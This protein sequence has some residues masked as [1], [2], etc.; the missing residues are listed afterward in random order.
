MPTNT[1]LT[2]EQQVVV[3]L[4]ADLEANALYLRN[5]LGNI[6][7]TEGLKVV[8]VAMIKHLK[9]LAETGALVKD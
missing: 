2:K 7:D 1:G 6:K 8:F 4:W 3:M 5:V 9:E